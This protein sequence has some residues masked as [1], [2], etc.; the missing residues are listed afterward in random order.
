MNKLDYINKLSF[1]AKAICFQAKAICHDSMKSTHPLGKAL[2]SVNLMS[3]KAFC[4]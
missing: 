4:Y 2:C 1:Q 3:T